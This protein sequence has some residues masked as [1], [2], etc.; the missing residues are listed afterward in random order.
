MPTG[1]PARHPLL[2]SLIDYAGLFPPASL[3]LPEALAEYRGL[4]DHPDSPLLGRFIVPASRLDELT[5]HL[6]LFD[7]ASPLRLCLLAVP[8]AHAADAGQAVE[9]AVATGETFVAAT[10]GR[11]R[12]DVIETRLTDR[13]LDDPDLTGRSLDHA[14]EAASPRPLYV[15]MPFAR[16]P[17]ASFAS[18]LILAAAREAGHTHLGAK[19][20]CGGDAPEDVPETATV[21][22]F[23]HTCLGSGIPFKATAGLH[24]PI[25]SVD[26]PHGP[27][28][29]F[30]NVFA[31]AV[32]AHVRHLEIDVLARI[33]DETDPEAF[34]LDAGGV[35]WRGVA[36]TSEETLQAR[37]A[38]ARSFGSCSFDEPTA[39]LRTLGWLEPSSTTASGAG[40]AIV[41]RNAPNPEI[42]SA[43][44]PGPM[45]VTT[46]ELPI[47]TAPLP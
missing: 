21:A 22:R 42:V 43:T 3:P 40:P 47:P 19:I 33:V 46:G 17:E 38:F 36:A 11:V 39:D 16:R 27:R 34:S 29:G 10:G 26:A 31:A 30:L 20:R 44:T 41:S 8:G 28:H 1:S 25:R 32:L 7:G 15:E 4:L 24:H 5:A 18:L 2:E 13:E 45:A 6:R 35:A 9:Y 12:V 37:A 14:A 23:L